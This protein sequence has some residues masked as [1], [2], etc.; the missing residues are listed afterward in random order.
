M[1]RK[2]KASQPATA[3]GFLCFEDK[4]KEDLWLILSGGMGMYIGSLRRSLHRQGM[5]NADTRELEKIIQFMS[6]QRFVLLLGSAFF[7]LKTAFVLIFII[8][9]AWASPAI[10]G[11]GPRWFTSFERTVRPLTEIV[12]APENWCID[13]FAPI[14]G[15]A[16]FGPEIVSCIAVSEIGIYLPDYS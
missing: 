7:L 12:L 13:A 14:A 15:F 3:R 16:V 11:G 4:A 10:G 5:S 2:R 9:Y 6:E 1:E 8:A